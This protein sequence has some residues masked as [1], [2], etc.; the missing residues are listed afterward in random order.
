[1]NQ[2]ITEIIEIDYAGLKNPLDIEQTLK[3]KY[4]NLVRWAIISVTG[5]K[6]KVS[7]TYEL[8]HDTI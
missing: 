2:I 7:V 8:T 1:M 4:N 3:R 6:A 5:A